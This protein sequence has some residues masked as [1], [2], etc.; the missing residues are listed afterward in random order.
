MMIFLLKVKNKLEYYNRFLQ[1]EKKNENDQVIFI[2]K[3]D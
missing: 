2:C 1:K 3:C